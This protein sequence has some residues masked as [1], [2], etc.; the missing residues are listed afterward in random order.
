M[1]L[2]RLAALAT[3]GVL[4]LGG[5]AVAAAQGGAVPEDLPAAPQAASGLEIAAQASGGNGGEGADAGGDT[6]EAFSA[7]VEGLELEGCQR[8]QTIAKAAQQDPTSFGEDTDTDPVPTDELP[9]RCAEGDQDSD[10]DDQSGQAGD[11]ASRQQEPGPPDAEALP[12]ESQ[13]GRDTAQAARSGQGEF[14]RTA[15]EQ[16]RQDGPDFGRRVADEASGGRSNAGPPNG[17]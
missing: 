1:P 17:N 9:G 3:T 5:A 8:G 11:A 16:A 10:Q 4:A 15:S 12:Q 13:H 14:G 2:T 7:W 6:A